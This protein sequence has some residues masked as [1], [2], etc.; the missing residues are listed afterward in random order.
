[1]H[2][3]KDEI[4]IS[5][6]YELPYEEKIKENFHS[7]AN[8]YASNLINLKNFIDILNTHINKKINNN[9]NLIKKINQEIKIKKNNLMFFEVLESK[10]RSLSLDAINEK[11]NDEDIATSTGTAEF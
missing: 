11:D 6:E 4:K 10:K 3:E 8:R 9:E 7:I 1:M 5:F 2:Y